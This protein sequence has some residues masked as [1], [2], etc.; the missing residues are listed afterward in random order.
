MSEEHRG[1][2]FVFWAALWGCGCTM[3]LARAYT[4][5]FTLKNILFGRDFSNLWT[6]GQLALE[7]LSYRAFDPNSFRLEIL[8]R[9]DLLTLQNYSYPPHALFLAAPFGTMPYFAALALFTAVGA[10]MFLAASRRWTPSNFP[11]LLGILTPAAT[12]NMWNGHYGLIL[13]ALWLWFF[14]NVDKRPVRAGAFAALLTLKPHMG[15]FIAL[16]ALARPTAAVAA[17]GATIALVLA[18]ILA[19]GVGNWTE[20]LFRTSSV[21]GQVL[22]SSAK[23]FYF[24]MMPS[25]FVAFGRGPAAIMLQAAFGIAALCLMLRSRRV[26]C[27]AAATATFLIVPYVFNYDM[28]VVSLGISIL[29]FR[30]WNEL[31]RWEKLILGASFFAPIMTFFAPW[32]CPPLLL[33][34][35]YLLIQREEIRHSVLQR[36]PSWSFKF[37]IAGAGAGVPTRGS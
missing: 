3:A 7:G 24:L 37:A 20:F 32:A 34:T 12:I 19:F 13:G 1:P 6:A 33:A 23:E 22:T 16:K 4:D 17:A 31:R 9:L 28:T 14:A 35:L 25:S 2:P 27:F 18:S 26:D 15:L 5:I 10:A 11:R 29:I 30:D 21:Q 36:Q 8:S